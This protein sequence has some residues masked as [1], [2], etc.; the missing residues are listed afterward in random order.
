[1][2]AGGSKTG[3]LN[4]TI[5]TIASLATK[6]KGQTL[7]RALV[8]ADDRLR[9]LRASAPANACASRHLNSVTGRARQSLSLSVCQLDARPAISAGV[10]EVDDVAILDDVVL[11]LNAE[12][13][14]VAG[15]MERAQL[16]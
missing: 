9:V 1:M 10:A 11:A 2:A 3:S 6:G 8:S 4:V 15:S 16:D 7:A 5:I 12:H 14:L 13:A